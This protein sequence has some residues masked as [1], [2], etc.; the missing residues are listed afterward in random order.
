MR[1]RYDT[2]R[3][4]LIA[5]G[6]DPHL[7]FF[8]FGLNDYKDVK[9]AYKIKLPCEVGCMDISSDGNHYALGLTDGTLIIKSKSL[10][11][12]TK[13]LDP[14]EQIFKSLEPTMK[15]TSKN[16]KYFFRGQYQVTPE[17]GDLI[18]EQKAKK[19]KLQPYEKAL[20]EF[21]YKEALNAGIETQNPEVLSA[22]FEELIERGGLEKALANRT[23]EELMGLIASLGWKIEDYR[24]QGLYLEILR[25]ILDMYSGVVGLSTKLDQMLFTQ[26]SSTLERDIAVSSQL[27]EIQGQLDMMIRLVEIRQAS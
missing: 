10:E 6:M 2:H 7:K 19:I 12:E 14:E 20:K 16:Y 9:I 26:L 25:V 8:E 11:P 5:G 21:K 24:Y 27:K 3:Q 13:E 17:I 1:V 18:A 15:S 23:E 4:R 22:L